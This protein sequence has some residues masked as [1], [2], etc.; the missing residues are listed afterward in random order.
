MQFSQQTQTGLRPPVPVTFT[1]LNQY[2]S[3]MDASNKGS[4][5]E[6]ETKNN[7]PA[8]GNVGNAAGNGNA[9]AGNNNPGNA[10]AGNSSG[11]G[12][13]GANQGNGNAGNS[14]NGGSTPSNGNGGNPGNGG[15]G[16]NSGEHPGNGNSGGNNPGD[17]GTGGGPSGNG[18]NGQ[19]S[20]NQKISLVIVVNS[21][22]VTIVA[23]LHE[24]LQVVALHAL[25]ETGNVGR[26]LTDWRMKTEA[27]DVL[28]FKQKV[29]EFGF[30]A[31]T[32]LFLSLKAGEGGC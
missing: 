1:H 21:E 4:N 7:T 25:Q 3:N 17:G 5:K 10:G 2:S 14:G 27:G 28:D 29:E 12:N 20:D 23:N 18:N 31:G 8:N 24:P 13:A 15:A 26:D 11:N 30:M 19:G 32:E 6:H 22:P 16:G 9:G